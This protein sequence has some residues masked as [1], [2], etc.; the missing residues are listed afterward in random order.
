MCVYVCVCVC[1]LSVTVGSHHS[2]DTCAC[3]PAQRF[4]IQYSDT[5]TSDLSSEA[6]TSD[7]PAVS[8]TFLRMEM[9]STVHGRA[10]ITRVCVCVEERT[11][12]SFLCVYLFTSRQGHSRLLSS[13][14]VSPHGCYLCRSEHTCAVG[15]SLS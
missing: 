3:R 14:H 1:A 10:V 13:F 6:V 2:A 9:N 7:L 15:S 5:L 12:I 8:F 11:S 4:A